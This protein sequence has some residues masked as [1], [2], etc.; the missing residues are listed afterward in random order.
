MG[1][2]PTLSI[3]GNYNR[4]G[5]S[6]TS[7]DGLMTVIGIGNGLLS[8][9][10]A[11]WWMGFPIGWTESAPSATASSRSAPERPSSNSGGGSHD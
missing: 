2:L 1:R 5:A 7:G 3:C 9:R 11:E 10:F 6:L 4:K 8:P